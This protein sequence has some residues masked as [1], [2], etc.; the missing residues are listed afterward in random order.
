MLFALPLQLSNCILHHV[1]T[2]ILILFTT[3]CLASTF[4]FNFAQMFGFHLFFIYLFL[5][6]YIFVCSNIYIFFY[7]RIRILFLV[8]FY[9]LG[10]F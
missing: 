2:K 9:I 4:R 10:S 6:L 3:N 7:Q 5:F 1:Y 8:N